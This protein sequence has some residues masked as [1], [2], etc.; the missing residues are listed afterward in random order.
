MSPGLWAFPPGIFS[1]SP[2]TPTALIFAF[3]SA[4]FFIN[5]ATTADPAISYVISSINLA[6]FKEIPPVS[7]QTPFPTNARGFDFDLTP[8]H[9]IV[10]R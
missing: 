3:L 5:P 6:G 4:K 7:K 9:S 1:T 8:F 2:T 10:T